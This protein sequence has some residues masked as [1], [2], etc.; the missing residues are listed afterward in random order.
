MA[1]LRPEK[2]V[3]EADFIQNKALVSKSGVKT[4]FFDTEVNPESGRVLDFGAV[5][6]DGAGLHT[7][8][9]REFT[10][11][12]KGSD[13]ICGHNALDHDL[14]Y[15]GD[16]LRDAG[17][18]IASCIDTLHLSPLLFPK[19]PYHCLV[20]DEKLLAD[21]LNNPH[22]DAIKARDLFHDEVAAWRGLSQE[23]KAI[24]RMLLA[25]TREF[26]AFFRWL[27]AGGLNE[28]RLVR[29]VGELIAETFA[30]KICAHSPVREMIGSQPV[31]LAYALA[32]ISADDSFSILP[33]WVARSF[34]RVETVLHRLRSRACLEGCDYCRARLD[35]KAAL[36]RWFGYDSFRT[37]GGEPLQEDAVRGA[38]DGKSLL[39]LF[40]TGGG[41]SITFQLPALM[42]GETESGLTV[43]I[44]PLQSLMKD[45]V[46][47]LFAAGIT[48]AVTIN[49]L[50][51]PI[52]RAKAIE[53]VADGSASILYISP[54]SLRSKTIE[55]LLLGRTISR[56]V[57]DEAHCFSAWG[58][59]FRPD[60]L[61]IGRFIR[62][63]TQKKLRAGP[64]AISC[65][66][67]TAK[68]QVVEDICEYFRQHLHV[69]LEIFSAAL[70]RPNLRFSV[71]EKREDAEKYAEL[72]A[73]LAAKE[74]PAIVY[75]SRVKRTEEIAA[76]LRGD[77]IYA[78]AY[79]GR[80]EAAKKTENQDAFM[81]GAARVMVA[82]TAFGMGVDKKDVGLVVHYDI[83][84]SLENYVQ[85]AGRAGRD[86]NISAECRVLFNEDDLNKHFI[87]LNQTR[88]NLKEIKDIWKA[89][90]EMARS[91]SR[92]RNSALEIARHAGWS[93][94]GA[95][96]ETRVATAVTALEQAGLLRRDQNCP[97][98][99]AS[100]I[101]CASM[102]EASER[103]QKSSRFADDAQ[104]R[105]AAR[106]VRKLFSARSI[107][108]AEGGDDAES[109][110]DYL[111]D[112]LG[113]VTARVY[114]IINL[115]RDEGILAMSRDMKAYVP[116][117]DTG[118][119]AIR[120]LNEFVA[121]ERFLVGEFG[122]DERLFN[123]KALNEAALAAGC[124]GCTPGRLVTI[125][126]YRD[127]AHVIRRLRLGENRVSIAL[128]ISRE[129]ALARIDKGAA[130]AAEVIRRLTAA[131][132]SDAAIADGE[133]RELPVEFSPIAL[134]DAINGAV[135]LKDLKATT[136]EVEEAIFYLTRLGLMKIEG[137]FLVVHNKM[138]I[139]RLNLEP[140]SQ[141]T[142]EDY[143]QLEKFYENR[144]LQ[145]HIVG[146]YAQKML[147]NPTEAQQF[148]EDYFRLNFQA[149]LSK[150]FS[151]AR[152]AELRRNITP[153]KY[154]ELF[155]TLTEA[156]RRVIDDKTS[157]AIIVAA[158][159]GSGKTKVLVHKLAALLL[160]EDV[161]H[162]QLL[163]LT[164]SRAAATEFK[165]RLIQLVGNAA[166]F[167]EIKTFHSYCFDL[168][169]RVGRIEARGI[170][171]VKEA[172]EAIERGD[173]EA[174][175]IAKSV[176]VI[177]EAQDM[178]ANEA[179]LV[180]TLMEKNGGLRVIAVGDDD[181]NIFAFRG[182][183]AKYMSALLDLD[184][185]SQYEL[186]VN[187]R[188]RPNLVAF[189]NQFVRQLPGRLKRTPISAVAREDGQ[190]THVR[191]A[192]RHLA[193]PVVCA[194]MSAELSGTTAVLTAT[195]QEAAI[196]VGLLRQRE[197]PAKLIQSN[198][199]F[200]LS[201]LVEVRHFLDQVRGLGVISDKEW[202]QAKHATRRRYPAT[203][204][205]AIL[206]LILRVFETA[207]P[208]Q[209]YASD[210]EMFL[211]ESAMEDFVEDGK[212][213]VI[214]VST[215]HK[216][217]GRE[218]DNVF[219][220][221][222]VE[223]PDARQLTSEKRRALYVALTRARSRLVIFT[224]SRMF[225][226]ISVSRLERR[227]D[228]TAHGE[229]SQ[230]PIYLTHRD[231]Y[232]DF[233]KSQQNRITALKTDARL[234]PVPTGLADEHKRELLR[235]SRGF[236]KTL[237]EYAAKGRVPTAAEVNF[238]VWWK[239]QE[240]KNEYVIILPLL[241]VEVIKEKS[242]IGEASG[243]NVV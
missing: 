7:R 238:S 62:E 235:Y 45:Q 61:Y 107:S 21:E 133:A 210:L 37:Y 159:P 218:F 196:V 53:Q 181:Q 174:S 55:N 70:G 155:E 49:G 109:R 27:D 118:A 127:T 152:L 184:D 147:V 236:Q 207:N 138:A 75:V 25:T 15:V 124:Q 229:S 234:F 240:E 106:I 16:A 14:R 208:V 90:K 122:E 68:Y 154:R 170:S 67:A 11:F 182:S 1:T 141:Y 80:M 135:V 102:I 211:R 57:I 56:F 31:E 98:I 153:R 94:I 185:S 35:P 74:C 47:N 59:D 239:P 167:V 140:R 114:E 113:L 128:L 5:R 215:M 197:Y 30:G 194:V 166:R 58:Q 13:F 226:D 26:G 212:G 4:L 213:G 222:G 163:M 242:G 142:R 115:L 219:L 192:S 177:D 230:F 24:Y 214:F 101:A 19:K 224:N 111:A 120:A 42:T 9:L 84:D 88:L 12:A 126:N 112:T 201:D 148:V 198:D 168:L 157:R 52:E 162:E 105:D 97:Q 195:N 92:I 209:K 189:T 64:V 136:S 202:E 82:T 63:L 172:A 83:S 100:S 110:V 175:R 123:T 85:E 231:I 65:F 119:R 180:W 44:S 66:T 6:S 18:D 38:L 72:R 179:A 190:I 216:A 206:A 20:K 34:S 8:A 32:L 77:G 103:I 121:I 139:E 81:S 150:Y 54:E 36:K 186:S 22:N 50:L 188:A 241:L 43:V 191:C 108:R 176:L 86:E 223:S 220:L 178:D 116:A 205:A 227:V 39:V 169:G 29:P 79:H 23:L 131:V 96:I 99:F 87:L 76:R 171:I 69:E 17:V 161:K 149:F 3:R 28:P 51:D 200:A 129:A 91:H 2:R 144:A 146:E 71:V 233:S 165:A 221:Y 48:R 204:G 160:M 151:R 164:F 46:D 137:G 89:I 232:L 134:R 203:N 183:S 33:K 156:Q 228:N 130:L 132:R 117:G 10:E 199:D 95:D 78:L 187:F 41:K 225:D 243:G 173:V 158:G 73:L 40:P 93:D 104:R 143:R 217:K 145:I 193:E 237:A 60:Y 125:L